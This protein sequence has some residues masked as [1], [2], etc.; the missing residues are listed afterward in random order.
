MDIRNIIK[1]PIV[2]EKASILKEKSNKYTFVVD[3]EANKFQIK[4]AVESLFNVRVESVHT[5]N[6]AGKSKR[7]GARSGFKSDWKKAIVK[8]SEGQEI[9]MVEEA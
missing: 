7:M 2:T 4:Q 1:K 5:A 9:Q 3:K 6:Y 8:L